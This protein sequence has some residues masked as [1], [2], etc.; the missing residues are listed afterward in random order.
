[1]LFK[2][3]IT[4]EDFKRAYTSCA[5]EAW[6]FHNYENFLQ[7]VNWTKEKTFSYNFQ[8]EVNSEEDFMG[9]AST[10]N[11]FKTFQEVYEKNDLEQLKKWE[12]LWENLE[13][14]DVVDYFG[15]AIV[16]GNE[17]GEYARQYFSHKLGEENLRFNQ[18]FEAISFD[19]FAFKDALKKTSE[20][21]SNNSKVKYLFEAA[22]EFDDLNLKTRCDILEI[23]ADQHVNLFEVKATSKVKADH[24]FDIVYQIY[25]LEKNGFI[26]D[27]VFLVTLNPEY[28]YGFDNEFLMKDAGKEIFQKYKDLTYDE[29][30]EDI[31]TNNLLAPFENN[32]LEDLDINRVFSFHE[33]WKKDLTFLDG[34]NL[35][36]KSLGIKNLLNELANFFSLESE[37]AKTFLKKN[38]CLTPLKLINNKKVQTIIYET[39]KKDLWCYHVLPW[40]DSNRQNIFNLTGSSSFTKRVKASIYYQTGKMYLDEIN[41][42]ES[43]NLVTAKG[44]DLFRDYHYR[45]FSVF[46]KEQLSGSL[47]AKDILDINHIESFQKVLNDFYQ[48]KEIYMYDFETVKWALPKFWHSSSYQQIPFQYSVDIIYDKNYDYNNPKS[49]Y[50]HDFISSKITDPRPEFIT[51]FI[52]DMLVKHH[53]GVYV[54]Y[55]K[56]FE[57]MVLK[58]LAV[59]FPKYA[60]PLIYI[61]QNTVDL[62]DFFKG[63]GEPD[64]RPWFLVYHPKFNGSYSIKKT[65][66]ALEPSFTYDDLIINKGDKAS[67]TF[68]QYLDKSIN[69]EAWQKHIKKTMIAYCNHDTLAMVVILKQIENLFETYEQ[70]KTRNE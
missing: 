52:N 38:S 56:T 9:N 62:M 7:A 48:E 1:M 36:E 69:E 47:L 15:D 2:T 22:F 59:Q 58:Y 31:K 53:K 33:N 14:F 54:A 64:F 24:F 10:I 51:N 32:L 67:Q 46:K 41:S 66:P 26:V 11:I 44:K 8:A 57:Q 20:V 17:V 42:L 43:L 39:G 16:D 28:V 25:I 19:H 37:N 55:N 63:K 61:A 50:H 13:G 3:N 21:L 49:M 12:A 23:K 45:M 70:E 30:L 27:Q 6:V 60:K 4:K 35:L 5:K 18:N 34:Y 40:Y 29:V 68:R 65:Q